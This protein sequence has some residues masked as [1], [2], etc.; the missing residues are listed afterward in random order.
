MPA[1]RK[2]LLRTSFSHCFPSFSS[3]NDTID[4]QVVRYD[5]FF[6][7]A[8]I[9]L[10]SA[11]DYAAKGYTFSV[12]NITNSVS[13]TN[14]L[15]RSWSYGADPLQS[16]ASYPLTTPEGIRSNIP[17]VFTSI[18]NDRLST[19]L[20]SSS[21]TTDNVF[22]TVLSALSS[23]GIGYN[24]GSA[25]KIFKHSS[26]NVNVQSS[27][28]S[29]EDIDEYLPKTGI[30]VKGDIRG[31]T[32]TYN[33]G[34]LALSSNDGST[35]TIPA[36]TGNNTIFGRTCTA[37][38]RRCSHTN[39]SLIRLSLG[40]SAGS[41]KAGIAIGFEKFPD[42]TPMGN[43]YKNAWNYENPL[44][45]I[46]PDSEY[47][48]VYSFHSHNDTPFVYESSPTVSPESNRSTY[49]VHTYDYNV[50]TSNILDINHVIPVKFKWYVDYKVESGVYTVNDI[51]IHLQGIGAVQDELSMQSLSA[52]IGDISTIQWVQDK[53]N[54]SASDKYDMF[55]ELNSIPAGD[56]TQYNIDE[57]NITTRLTSIMGNIAINTIEGEDDA[58]FNSAPIE[59]P[60]FIQSI[61]LI[62]P[63]DV[64]TSID[65]VF[66]QPGSQVT[67]LNILTDGSSSTG[68]I[69]IS[70]DGT[71]EIDIDPEIED[72]SGNVLDTSTIESINVGI[73][74]AFQ[75]QSNTSYIT[76][77]I[78]GVI[79]STGTDLITDTNNGLVFPGIS[80]ST[81]ASPVHAGISI[82]PV[83]IQASVF[84]TSN[85]QIK[86]KENQL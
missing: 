78:P 38:D 27:Y 74:D 45:A 26:F 44:Q 70:G 71:L 6:P 18:N 37:S 47:M 35:F 17:D 48:I 1:Q 33:T 62:T 66:N 79:S 7:E 57:D 84:N 8:F 59:Y 32:A 61:P 81:T 30:V 63:G 39:T 85:I 16:L 76:C 73:C 54:S 28:T 80:G 14:S 77:N 10:A 41:D 50:A 22:T 3:T 65:G 4:R 42:T 34:I 36:L 60:P 56:K 52:Q 49:I 75:A 12:G 43:E 82:S 31:F 68:T 25:Q 5:Q 19:S 72:A 21:T 11:T 46:N 2:T 23:S 24:D 64:V 83:N 9:S 13:H 40:R 20:I 29:N 55:V 15:Y 69:S 86:F 53:L 51:I 58:D 67:D